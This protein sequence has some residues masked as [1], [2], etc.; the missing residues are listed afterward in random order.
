MA[1]ESGKPKSATAKINLNELSGALGDLGTFLPHIIGAISLAHL[2]PA[3]VLTMFGLFYLATG[4]FYQIPMAVQPMKAASAA[5]LIQKATP[6]EIAGAGLVL[7]GLLAFLA[8]TGLMERLA[9]ITSRSV[10]SGIQLGL[11]LSLS[12]LGLK[13]VGQNL[14]LGVLVLVVMLPFGFSRSWPSAIT[15]VVI[16]V[17]YSLLTGKLTEF[18]DLKLGLHLPPLVIPT[19][20]DV[21]T[22]IFKI[23]IP[24]IPLTITNAI[25]V[26]SFLANRLFPHAT[27]VNVRNLALTQGLGNLIAAPFG[28]YLMCHGGGGLVSH[29]RF[30]ARTAAAPVLLGISLLLAGLFLGLE[31]IKIFRLIPEPVLGALLVYGGLDLARSMEYPKQNQEL[32]IILVVGIVSVWTNP[33]WGYILGLPLAYALKKGW[34]VP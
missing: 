33:S 8:A 1:A 19:L 17:V 11:G 9:R 23:V 21:Q 24:Q 22:G 14:A 20:A 30:G 34:L 18:P 15:G 27:R 12:L 32:F 13:M 10:T 29:Y 28:G 2:N 7:G 16:G 25:I 26:S 4:L 3:G 6:G 5:I 31:A